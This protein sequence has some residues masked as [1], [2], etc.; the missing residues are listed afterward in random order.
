MP[1]RFL[2]WQEEKKIMHRIARQIEGIPFD[3]YIAITRGG[4]IPTALLSHITGQRNI[5]TF[6]IQRY[7]EDKKEKTISNLESKNLKHFRNQRILLIDDLLDHGKTMEFV[8]HTLKLYS[9]QDIKIAVIYWKPRSII[10]P[11]FYV[12]K[13]DNDFWVDFNWEISQ[14]LILPKIN[15]VNGEEEEKC[16]T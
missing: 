8:V 6:C 5:D 11:N 10:T 13:C 14:S 9:P 3:W 1:G 15:E 16:L 12:E 4:L 7:G 2:F